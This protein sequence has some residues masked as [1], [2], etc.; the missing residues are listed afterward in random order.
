MRFAPDRTC[1]PSAPIVIALL[2]A[3]TSTVAG[4]DVTDGVGRPAAG[5][6]AATSLSEV[7]SPEWLASLFPRQQPAHAL[8]APLMGPDALQ[9]TA[10]DPTAGMQRMF[11]AARPPRDPAPAARRALATIA[12]ALAPEGLSQGESVAT[13]PNDEW[14]VL[15]QDNLGLTLHA[16]DAW[17]VSYGKDDAVIAVISDGVDLQHPDLVDKIWR[18][19][20]EIAGNGVDDDGNGYVDDV[21][22][23][24]FGGDE[25]DKA[26]GDNDPNPISLGPQLAARNGNRGTQMAGIAAASTHNGA[27]IAGVS[28]GARIMPIKTTF[29]YSARGDETFAVSFYPKHITEGVCYAARN[30][31]DVILIGG[32]PIGGNV[33]KEES[34]NKALSSLAEAIAFAGRPSR[35]GAR[36]VPVV[37]PAGECN[38]DNSRSV[39]TSCP[40][41]ENPPIFPASSSSP[42]VIGVTAM[43]VDRDRIGIRRRTMSSG[44]W[45]DIAAPGEGFITTV[46]GEN[47]D[48]PY[49]MIATNDRYPKVDDFAAAHVAGVIGVMTSINPTLTPVQVLGNLCRNARR[50]ESQGSFDLSGDGWLRNDVFGCGILDF[51]Q[52]VTHMP[53]KIRLRNAGSIVHE[54]VPLD[55]TEALRPMTNPFINVGWWVL[56]TDTTWL[57]DAPAPQKVGQVSTRMIRLNVESLDRWAGGLSSSTRLAPQEVR[58]CPAD[59]VIIHQLKYTAEDCALGATNGCKCLQLHLHVAAHVYRAYLP[60]G[61]SGVAASMP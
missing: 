27:G 28:W 34:R 41:G 24:D 32:L 1:R 42:N 3:A 55:R 44:A 37:V 10:G 16:Q 54:F 31:A 25:W 40:E 14:Y 43:R 19:P 12:S 61:V 13:R 4:A 49:Q 60:I 56:A 47:A 38:F 15:Q 33:V 46:N 23:W 39:D 52:T 53:F 48:D 9:G 58:A 26:D 50:D 30:G 35:E 2:I 20:G 18:N 59:P 45:V 7:C 22:G 36:G 29:K 11:A 5:V 8:R 21:N 57:D 6:R 51:D 17:Q